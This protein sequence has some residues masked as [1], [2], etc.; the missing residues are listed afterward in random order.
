MIRS[1]RE[2]ESREAGGRKRAQQLDKAG[3][4]KSR[5]RDERQQK[6]KTR[7]KA[8]MV[9]GHVVASAGV[10]SCRNPAANDGAVV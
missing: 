5:G 3:E 8:H 7:N 6:K 10:Y 4:G 1:E 2:T 9:I